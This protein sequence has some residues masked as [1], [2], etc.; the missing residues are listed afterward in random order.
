MYTELPFVLL[1]GVILE[2]VHLEGFRREGEDGF[3]DKLALDHPGL[4]DLLEFL[5][6]VL[7]KSEVLLSKTV[8]FHF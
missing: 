6:R 7:D 3:E 8:I 4:V 2:V 1:A 5:E